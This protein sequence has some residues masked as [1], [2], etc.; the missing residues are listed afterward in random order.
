MS[1]LEQLISRTGLELATPSQPV[2]EAVPPV[3]EIET[4]QIAG[5]AEPPAAPRVVAPPTAPVPSVSEAVAVPPAIERVVF[6]PHPPTDLPREVD[7]FESHQ[8]IVQPAPPEVVI[9]ERPAEIIIRPPLATAADRSATPPDDHAPIETESPTRAQ[10]TTD[11]PQPADRPGSSRSA[12]ARMPTIIDVRRWVAQS[13]SDEPPGDVDSPG[14]PVSDLPQVVTQLAALPQ[15]SQRPG[16]RV[17]DPAPLATHVDLSIGSVHVVV[18][19]P[20]QQP[21]V[22]P[23]PN[24]SPV[25][26]ADPLPSWSR[27]ARRYV[28]V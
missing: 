16:D 28:R 24:Q 4:E 23:R 3:V 18:E 19:P 27:L 17:F 7:T 21:V 13:S 22:T 1:Y 6:A 8:T 2:A 11:P 15:P 12:P 9:A 20:P 5:D 26:A 10:T 25:A 14:A